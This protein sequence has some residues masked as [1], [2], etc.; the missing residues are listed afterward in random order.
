M[1]Y[2]GSAKL[3]RIRKSAKKGPRFGAQKP[4]RIY[5]RRLNPSIRI[6]RHSV[7]PLAIDLCDRWSRKQA[8]WTC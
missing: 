6:V 4:I 3:S 7:I 2:G 8:L 1:D 5:R